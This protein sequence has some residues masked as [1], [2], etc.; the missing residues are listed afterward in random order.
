MSKNDSKLSFEVVQAED[1]PKG[2]TRKQSQWA[3]IAEQAIEA[4]EG[5]AE[6]E[7]VVFSFEDN[8]TAQGKSSSLRT[9]LR[10]QGL[11]DRV[12]VSVREEKIFLSLKDTEVDES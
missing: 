11:S 4:L 2:A 10:T 12:K 5:L 1:M 9:Y 6:G 3:G 7:G 8:K